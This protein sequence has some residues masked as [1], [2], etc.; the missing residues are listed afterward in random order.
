VL[1]SVS[2]QTRRLLTDPSS[3]R[4]NGDLSALTNGVACLCL[5]FRGKLLV[6]FRRAFRGNMAF[7]GLK[8]EDGDFVSLPEETE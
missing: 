8:N 7:L 2:I 1:A 5:C 3:I 4:E 6:E